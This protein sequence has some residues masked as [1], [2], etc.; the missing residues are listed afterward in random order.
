LVVGITIGSTASSLSI[1]TNN[2]FLPAFLAL[3]IWV[4]LGIL[5]NNITLRS[6]RWGKILRG[7]GTVLIENGR[8]LEENL[9]KV[10]NLTIDD[11]LMM[12]RTK[13]VFEVSQVEFAILELNGQLSVLKKSQHRPL[14]PKDI[15][16]PTSYEGLPI[17][18]IYDGRVIDKN[19]AGARLDRKWLMDTLEA[20]GV[21]DMKDV[22]FAQLSTDGTL[23]VDLRN[24]QPVTID[25]SDYMKQ[26]EEL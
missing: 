14:T 12:L 16:V 21:K 4:T 9:R 2:P 23:Y 26:L 13:D 1:E 15:N 10:P 6:R 18:L 5:L 22:M 11:L 24:D 7:E 3:V 17:E 20:R 19:L 8:I 25:I